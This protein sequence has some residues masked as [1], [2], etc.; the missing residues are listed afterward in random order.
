VFSACCRGGT[1][2]QL[3]KSC[4]HRV[5]LEKMQQLLALTLFS[6]VAWWLHIDNAFDKNLRALQDNRH[7]VTA[8]Q[9]FNTNWSISDSGNL[10]MPPESTTQ[11]WVNRV[12][13][14]L[15]N[16]ELAIVLGSGHWQL[17]PVDNFAAIEQHGKL[18]EFAAA[19]TTAADR[20][21]LS[22]YNIDWENGWRINATCASA[23]C[24]TDVLA[25]LIGAVSPA[26][27]AS[28]RG[29]TLCVDAGDPLCNWTRTVY[30]PCGYLD[31]GGLSHYVAAGVQRVQ[32]MGTYPLKPPWTLKRQLQMLDSIVAAVGEAGPER[33]GI[34]LAYAAPGYEGAGVAWTRAR[35]HAFLAAVRSAGVREVDMFTA[36]GRL[37]EPPEWWWDELETFEYI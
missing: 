6:R 10:V 7:L 5:L 24:T 35:L 29:V 36:K 14:A 4:L 9:M 37:I 21:N 18:S 16:T 34:G 26:L 8:L 20:F 1:N 31:V 12:R 28:G 25:R 22:G 32:Q 2:S 13:Q 17:A 30:G 15:P 27:G 23:P 3:K 11:A 33:V 19:L